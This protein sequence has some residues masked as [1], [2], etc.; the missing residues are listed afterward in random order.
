VAR[1]VR[2]LSWTGSLECATW[3]ASRAARWDLPDPAVF[4]ALVPER[5]VLS[6]VN[7]QHEDKG[8]V[9]NVDMDGNNTL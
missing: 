2:G 7:T 4:Q 8:G 9:S 1:R 3:F 6:Y 5:D